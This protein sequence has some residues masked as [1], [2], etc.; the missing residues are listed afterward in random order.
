LIAISGSREF[1]NCEDTSKPLI[2]V[3]LRFRS[4]PGAWH[5]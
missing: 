1:Q 3:P 2:L 5:P 4:S